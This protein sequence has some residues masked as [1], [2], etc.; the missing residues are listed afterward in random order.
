MLRYRTVSKINLTLEITGLLPDGR[1]S[2]ET[3]FQAIDYGDELL[4]ETADDLTLHCDDVQ[5]GPQEDNLAWK[6][7]SLLRQATGTVKGARLR[8]AKKV[9][10]GAGLG[11]GSGD[12]AAVLVAC[13]RLWALDLGEER[14]EELGRELGADVPFLVRGGAAWA[15]GAGDVLTPC[16]GLDSDVHI[17]VATPPMPVATGWAYRAWDE[18]NPSPLKGGEPLTKFTALH[19]KDRFGLEALRGRL[20][21]SFEEVVYPRFPEIEQVRREMVDAGAAAALLS[22]SG[23]SVF[24]LFPE[25]E[26]P[27]AILEGWDGRGVRRRWCRPAAGPTTF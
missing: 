21:N 18:R 27:A 4:L 19:S 25:R 1:H 5:L 7:A 9:P 6:A 26:A 14:L 8:L 23:S 11:G 13:N 10:Y 16:Q 12:A 2:L 3:W 15:T 17:L 20:S 22:G 24:G